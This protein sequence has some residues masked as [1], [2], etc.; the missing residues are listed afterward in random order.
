MSQST[1]V[2]SREDLMAL[3]GEAYRSALKLLKGAC[4]HLVDTNPPV[5]GA[6]L[7]PAPPQA[8]PVFEERASYEAIE[9]LGFTPSEFEALYA[10]AFVG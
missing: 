8:S 1:I 9:R 6:D 3:E 2:N 5:E 7:M 10:A 4:M